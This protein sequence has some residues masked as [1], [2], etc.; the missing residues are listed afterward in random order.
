MSCQ[1]GIKTAVEKYVQNKPYLNFDGK[2]F[3]EVRTSPKEK[4]NPENYYG[5]SRSVAD[6]L[7]KAI[8]SE[9]A[10]GKVFYPKAYSDKVGVIIAPTVKQLDALN[11][12]DEAELDK[13]LAELDLEIPEANR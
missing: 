13:A 10:L 9:I 4:V 8:N 1:T 11:A 6:T 3:I 12:K 2:D 5:V 7:N